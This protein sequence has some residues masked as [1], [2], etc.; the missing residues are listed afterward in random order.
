M[1]TKFFKIIILL[2]IILFMF[3]NIN[4]ILTFAEY[5]SIEFDNTD[6][7]DD[8]LSSSIDGEDFNLYNYPYDNNGI[9]HRPGIINF[10]EFCYSKNQDLKGLYGLYIYFYNPQGL[11]IDVDSPLN[12]VQLAISYN[13]DGLPDDYEKFLIE[14][15]S[16]SEGDYENLFYKFKIIDHQSA[17]DKTIYERVLSSCRRYD[18]SGIELN[19]EGDMNATEFSV[20]GTYK[21]IGYAEGCGEDPEAESTLS[22]TVNDLETVTLNVHST[23]YR[24][25]ISSAGPGHQNELNSVYFSVDNSLL[26]NYGNLQR[27]KAEWYEYKT[28]P[29]VVTSDQDFYNALLSY[30][31]VYNGDYNEDNPIRM[32]FGKD[33]YSVINNQILQTTTTIINY[34]WSYNIECCNENILGNIFD[35]SSDDK[36]PYLS[37]LF[38]TNGQNITDYEISREEL[39]NYILNYNQSNFNGLLT[40]KSININA[41][42]F[43]GQVEE[44]R[45]K[46]YNCVEI[47]SDN[48]FNM[49]SYDSNH[50]W[51]DKLLDY[52]FW[53]PDETGDDYLGVSPIYIVKA[54]DLIGTDAAVSDNLLIDEDDVSDF[55][56]FSAQEMLLGRSV[57]LFRFAQTDYFSGLLEAYVNSTDYTN[58]AYMSRETVFFDF[59]IIQLTFNKEG[60][61]KIIPVVMSPIDII[62]DITPPLTPINWLNRLLMLIAMIIFI[63]IIFPFL[64]LILNLIIWII[65]IPFKIIGGVLKGIKKVFKGRKE[66]LYYKEIRR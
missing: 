2:N 37:F 19:I 17:D 56:L 9:I 3:F 60:V 48:T 21:F 16:K 52:G 38:N 32:N 34:N 43:Q 26:Q 22:G 42:L 55:K 27:I 28:S 54:E 35:I 36:C 39:N 49:L 50:N 13:S 46:G 62:N 15:C 65:K 63:I 41:D 10:V 61:F 29:I 51:F 5:D 7:L 25:G 24:T 23:H 53:A 33:Y 59:D 6:V 40:T 31:G 1:K 45:T 44:G 64:P 30:K 47:D 20:G 14:F 58:K 57:F 11:N 18:I 12:K 8:L 4:S 66:D